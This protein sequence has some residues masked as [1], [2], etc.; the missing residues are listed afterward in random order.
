MKG[1][2]RAGGYRRAVIMLFSISGHRLIDQENEKALR[3]FLVG[4]HS[5]VRIPKT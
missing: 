5:E 1:P 2:A 4:C 3:K